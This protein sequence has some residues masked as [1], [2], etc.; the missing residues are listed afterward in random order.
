MWQAHGG[1]AKFLFFDQGIVLFSETCMYPLTVVS[2]INMRLGEFPLLIIFAEV[3]TA[4][5]L[6]T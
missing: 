1:V 4:N 6:I 3:A 5:L 2:Y